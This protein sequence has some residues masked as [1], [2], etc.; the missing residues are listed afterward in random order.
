MKTIRAEVAV[1]GGGPAGSALAR[2]LAL[3]G[4]DVVQLARPDAGPR[5]AES[6]APGVRVHLDT[7]GIGTPAGRLCTRRVV[8]WAGEAEQHETDSLIVDRAALDRQLLDA[9]SAAG[10]RVVHAGVDSVGH[11][12]EWTL[13]AGGITVETPFLADAT[14]RAGLLRRPRRHASPRTFAVRARWNAVDA[15][16]EMRVAVLPNGWMWGVA[17]AGGY[18][19]ALF[20]DRDDLQTAVAES[21]LFPFLDRP[22]DV[23]HACDATPFVSLEPVTEDSILAGDAVCAI[24]PLS[25]SGVQAA[26][27]SA[28]TAGVIINTML[29]RPGSRDAAMQFYAADVTRRFERHAGWT[30]AHYASAAADSP[31]WR[32]RAIETAGR[33]QPAFPPPDALLA[34]HPDAV[35][36]RPVIRGDL[37][38]LQRV[39]HTPAGDDVAFLGGIELAPL[40]DAM[41]EVMPDGL[42]AAELLQRWPQG[43]LQWLVTNEV[44]YTASTS[45]TALTEGAKK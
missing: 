20:A 30:G 16:D 31:F 7:L 21:D 34:V 33:A 3:L 27:G 9:A 39:V 15:P 38:A 44:V 43:V 28:I 17:A 36:E 19:I 24:D 1:A 22:P 45:R 42:T 25:S 2:R 11:D 35:Q 23:S 32:A 13:H 37:I 10:V 4:F 29:T 41:V 18:E 40:V 14:G 12:R 5:F 26:L 6:L 8:R